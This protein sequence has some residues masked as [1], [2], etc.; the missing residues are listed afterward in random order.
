M[1]DLK[2]PPHK[3]KMFGVVYDKHGDIKVDDWDNLAPELKQI[4]QKEL[5]NGCKLSNNFNS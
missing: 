5:D 3:I 2:S 4:I 1:I